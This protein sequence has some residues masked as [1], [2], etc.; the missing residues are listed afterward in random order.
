[1]IDFVDGIFHRKVA[2]TERAVLSG[3]AQLPVVMGRLVLT[4]NY[5]GVGHIA[6]QRLEQQPDGV[7]YPL[8]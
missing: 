1:M 2:G 5:P 4:E 3:I 8:L 7:V 6:L